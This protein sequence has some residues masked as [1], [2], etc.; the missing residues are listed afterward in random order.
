MTI[1]ITNELT[2]L[3]GTEILKLLNE[4]AEN[5]KPHTFLELLYSTKFNND[6]PM[7]H[8]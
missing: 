2:T 6:T 7:L 8:S 4:T 3:P 1:Y 5:Q